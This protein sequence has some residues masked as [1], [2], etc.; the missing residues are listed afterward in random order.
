M[1]TIKLVPLKDNT[2]YYCNKKYVVKRYVTEDLK[3]CF[4]TDALNY[5][6]AYKASE[7]G[8]STFI[9]EVYHQNNYHA[10]PIYELETIVQKVIGHIATEFTLK[11]NPSQYVPNTKKKVIIIK[12]NQ[13]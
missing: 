12:I 6:K 8:K 10:Y 5:S 13:L 7:D 11:I 2:F 3:F 1:K 9:D 4:T